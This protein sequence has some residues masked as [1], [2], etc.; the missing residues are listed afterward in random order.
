L[1]VAL[2]LLVFLPA[3]ASATPVFTLKSP[4]TGTAYSTEQANFNGCGGTASWARNP[5]FN[6]TNGHA[7]ATAQ[8]TQPSCK[9]SSAYTDTYASVQFESAAFVLAS[10]HHSIKLKWTVS[11]SFDLVATPGPSPQTAF[12]YGDVFATAYVY[13]ATN[14]TFIDATH[15]TYLAYSTSNGS[16]VQSFSGVRLLDFVNG[17]FATG[18]SYQ[19]VAYFEV[20]VEADVGVGSSTASSLFN[21]G[22]S[23]KVAT[24]NLITAS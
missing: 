17:T 22:T 24:L 23:G 6:L 16:L 5:F 11:F 12:A 15:T 1:A 19:V 20:Y 8:S 21:A 13:D 10:G 18:H 4:F 2:G 7:Y 3:V 9:H 14:S